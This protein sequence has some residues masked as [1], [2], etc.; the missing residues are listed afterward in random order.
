MT[1]Q[2]TTMVTGVNHTI[3]Q[4]VQVCRVPVPGLLRCFPSQGFL[5]VLV[6]EAR[7]PRTFP[8]HLFPDLLRDLFGLC[9]GRMEHVVRPYQPLVLLYEV[10]SILSVIH[11]S[12]SALPCKI[13]ESQRMI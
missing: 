13:R 4:F 7:A 9:G 2:H 12:I 3:G 8:R 6:S 10:S 5:L 1:D 11:N